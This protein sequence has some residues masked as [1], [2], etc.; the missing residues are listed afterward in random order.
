MLIRVKIPNILHMK[1]YLF[2]LMLSF[3]PGLSILNAQSPV[4]WSFSAQHVQDD[5]YDLYFTATIGQG[6]NVYSMYLPNEDGPVATSINFESTHQKT[7]GKATES[8][9]KPEYKKSGH[10]ETFDM[11]LTKYKHDLTLVQRVKC[12]DVSKPVKGFVTYMTCNDERCLPPTDPEF[13][14]DLSK[15]SK[16][17]KSDKKE[18]DKKEETESDKKGDDSDKKNDGDKGGNNPVKWSFRTEKNWRRRI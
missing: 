8:A 5:E 1:K 12:S 4:S 9:S 18:S 2:Y 10:D 17:G 7:V 3:I 13:S 14:I 11:Q 16:V 15:L 6:W